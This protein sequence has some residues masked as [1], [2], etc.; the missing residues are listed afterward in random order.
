MKLIKELSEVLKRLRL[1]HD[2][3]VTIGKY[4]KKS[5]SNKNP[6]DMDMLEAV[7]ND[8]AASDKEMLNLLKQKHG[9]IT[10]NNYNIVR[11]RLQNK[12]ASLTLLVSPNNFNWESY[13]TAYLN[14]HRYSTIAHFLSVTPAREAC[15]HYARKAFN[16]T[17]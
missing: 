12:L 8:K 3:P 13:K 10:Q 16:L 1:D 7:L 4:Q 9:G 17:S 6:K 14:A 2:L 15:M 5:G 11:G